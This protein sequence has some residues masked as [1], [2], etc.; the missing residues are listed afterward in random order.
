MRRAAAPHRSRSHPSLSRLCAS[1]VRCGRNGHRRAM[2][3]TLVDRDDAQR[4]YLEQR[5]KAC[6]VRLQQR[7]IDAVASSAANIRTFIHLSLGDDASNTDTDA[8]TRFASEEPCSCLPPSFPPA[9]LP[10]RP[11]PRMWQSAGGGAE[12]AGEGGCHHAPAARHSQ[13]TSHPGAVRQMYKAEEQAALPWLS[14]F[15]LQLQPHLP[16]CNSNP[17]CR[18]ATPTLPAAM[19]RASCLHQ[20]PC[21]PSPTHVL[22]PVWVVNG[23][24]RTVNGVW[25]M[26]HGAWRM[27]YGAWRMVN[28]ARCMAHGAWQDGR[29]CKLVEA[30]AALLQCKEEA[31]EQQIRA[32]TYTRNTVLALQHMR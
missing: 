16:P 26:A 21:H 1:S 23:A 30:S 28:G 24:R 7:V 6:Q 25:R 14:P 29:R 9:R 4:Q 27:V 22:R 11:L 18:H 31:V 8:V 2:N 12:G 10:D 17:T 15:D 5:N 19:P 13:H 20:P 3:P 32:A